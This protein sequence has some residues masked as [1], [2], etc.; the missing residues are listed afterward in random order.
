LIGRVIFAA[1]SKGALRVEVAGTGPDD[2]TRLMLTGHGDEHEIELS[3]GPYTANVTNIGTGERQ[4]F[5]F[6]VRQPETVFKI[7]SDRS[8]RATW[9]SVSEVE[10]R[11]NGW[12]ARR[13]GGI[14]LNDSEASFLPAIRMRMSTRWVD[15][16]GSVLVN[17]DLP[18]ALKL[19]RSGSWSANPLVRVEFEG[20]GGIPM[21]CF[22]PLFAGGTLVRW[23]NEDKQVNEIVPWEPKSAAIVGSLANSTRDELPMILQWAAGSNEADAIQ[24]ILHS[25]EDPW[26]AA[27]TGL[28]LANSARLK[29]SGSL[30]S[31]LASRNPWISDLAVLAAWGRATDSPDDAAGCL[32][33]LSQA[34]EGGTIF[35]W[36]TCTIADRLLSA[37]V[38]SS[39]PKLLR[40]KARKER[41]LWKKLTADASR[42]GPCLGLPI[43]R[44]IKR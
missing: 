43:C 33:T 26:I 1:T 12:I 14:A 44:Q 11:P 20:A 36:Q 32:A 22:V 31:R 13:K 34:R 17:A 37:L 28:A 38:S 9:R 21:Q 29:Q 4:S 41:G 19:V 3:G 23:N 15:F 6:D 40:A 39:E 27:A 35:F 42:I 18:T 2:I 30:L 7:E 16:S 5:N 24:S 10:N 8:R 25:R